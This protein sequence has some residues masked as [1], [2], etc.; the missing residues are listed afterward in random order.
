MSENRLGYCASGR[1]PPVQPLTG[2]SDRG[3]D[4]DHTRGTNDMLL[5]PAIDIKD[6]KCVRLREGR[7]DTATVFSDAPVEMAGALG[8]SRRPPASHRRSRRSGRRRAEERRGDPRHR[9]NVSRCPGPGR[10]RD[11][12]R[13]DGRG[14]HPGRVCGSSSW[15]PERQRRRTS[16]PISASNFPDMSSS[17]STPRAGRSPWT[18]GRSCPNHDPVDLARRFEHDGVEA[19]VFTDVGRDGDDE[20]AERRC[21]GRSGARGVGAGH[22]LGGGSGTSTTCAPL[23]A[24]ADEG[25]AGG[26]HGA[27]DLR[28]HPGGIAGAITGRAIY[29]G[30]LDFAEAQRLVD[31]FAPEEGVGH[32]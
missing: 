19:F 11:P 30:T 13:R 18:D 15:G 27:R 20:R 3:R 9:R 31:E 24:V 23:C 21:D 22:R 5:I 2:G 6:R 25:I 4:H 32:S 14:I 26:D 29:E 1:H 8:R 16:S 17:A 12:R 7:M 28:R 10:W